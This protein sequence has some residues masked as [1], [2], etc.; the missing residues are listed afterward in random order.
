MSITYID[1]CCGLGGFR[2]GMEQSGGFEC[3][4]SCD[5][6]SHACSIYKENFGD[7]PTG[8]LEQVVVENLPEFDLLCAGFP[9]QPFSKAG[10]GLG[11]KDTR[12]T[13]FFEILRII[14]NKSPKVVF[15]EN[16]DNLLTLD[17]GYNLYVILD[18]LHSLGYHVTYEVLTA[19][20]FGV[21]Q[22]RERIVIIASKKIFSFDSIIKNSVKSMRDFIDASGSY[23][24]SSQ[25]TLLDKPIK[26]ENTGLFFV[27]YLNKELRK[28]GINP[29]KKHLSRAHKQPYRIYSID[30]C[31]PTISSQEKSGRYW[32]YDGV[33]V[34]KLSL[35]ECFRLMGFPS[36]FKQ[37]GSK[38]DLYERIGNSVCVPMI[39]SIADA[40][41]NFI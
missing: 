13:V 19:S 34:R 7:D 18:S 38:S 33:G 16:V 9:C 23:I 28:V 30:G 11:F 5:N 29:T 15:L 22:S 37:V 4:F 35:D 31:H 24:P 17:N 39:K 20:D 10:Q 1:L 36:S 41:K 8:D 21:P 3:V 26:Q 25:Y 6:N 14:E 27:G 32:V 40:I 2:L 12:G